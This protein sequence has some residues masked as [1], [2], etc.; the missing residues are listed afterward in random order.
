[1]L[2]FDFCDPAGA[3][4][5]LRFADPVELIVARDAGE[6]RPALRA[7]Q[8]AS[9]AGL[10]A[11]GFVSYEAAPAFD[12]AFV[13]RAGAGPPPLWFGLFR[14]PAEEAA[15]APAGSFQLDGWRPTI[16]RAAHARGVGAVREAI[17]RGETYQVNYTL[18]LRSAFAGD[19]L[20]LYERLRRAQ[21]AGYCAYLDT[22]S[23]QVLSLSPELFFQ[24]RGD[25]IVTRPMKGTAR[26]GRWPAEDRELAAWLAASEKNRAENLMIV[27]LLRNDLGR[28]ARVGTVEAPRLFEVERYRTVHQL[29]STVTA[30][31]RPA[32]TLEDVFAA[33]F[34]CGSITGAPKVQTMKL[35]A[36][37]EDAPRGVLLRRGRPGLAGRRGGVQRGYSHAGD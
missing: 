30:Q 36:S 17:G 25:R 14:A 13:V 2:I 33:L 16:D 18:R 15:P 5:R 12:P 22:G 28:I 7:V 27:D 21:A 11:A 1:M 4:R 26:R 29:T 32:T 35:I 23:Y 20:A 3:P 6:V 31:V 10:Y 8:R 37:L 9:A 34:P 19:G 24:W